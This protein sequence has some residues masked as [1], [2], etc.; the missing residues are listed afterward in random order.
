MNECEKAIKKIA[1]LFVCL[2]I[3][4]GFAGSMNVQ[5]ATKR[6]ESVKSFFFT[7][8]RGQTAGINAQAIITE[9][10]KKKGTKNIFTKRDCFLAYSRAY[11]ASAPKVT[12]SN[13]VHRASSNGDIVKTFSPWVK[14]SY[15]WDVAVR[16]YGGGSYNT[17]S[18]S[19]KKTTKRVSGFSYTVYCRDTLVPTQAGSV[20]VVLKTK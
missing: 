1:M 13:G 19:Y 5:A 14:G 11:T 16:P 18:V 15:L 2:N 20:Y 9:T 4:L 6:N 3:I 12:R 10:Y 8:P 7:T 17:T